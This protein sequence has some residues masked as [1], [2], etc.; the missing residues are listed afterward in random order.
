MRKKKKKEQLG[1]LATYHNLTMISFTHIITEHHRPK[2]ADISWLCVLNYTIVI[3]S[4]D[5]RII[6]C[7]SF[8]LPCSWS[9]MVVIL[10]SFS[11]TTAPTD[12]S[13]QT[14]TSSLQ[15]VQFIHFTSQSSNIGHMSGTLYQQVKRLISFRSLLSVVL[16]MLG[17]LVSGI[18]SFLT[19]IMGTTGTFKESKKSHSLPTPSKHH[20]DVMY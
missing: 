7:P 5:S 11:L 10:L 14:R 3:L 9:H 4:C 15:A 6:S 18:S 16:E 19:S 1:S 12:S 2:R 8:I 17:P 13:E 20:N